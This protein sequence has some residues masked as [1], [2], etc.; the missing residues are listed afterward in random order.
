MYGPLLIKLKK[1]FTTEVVVFRLGENTDE[2]GYKVRDSIGNVLTQRSPGDAISADEILGVFC[3]D[4]L[5][6]NP[7]RKAAS[8]EGNNKQEEKPETQNNRKNDNGKNRLSST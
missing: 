3:T 7:K 1:G 8:T 6:L 2:I 5:N 4:C